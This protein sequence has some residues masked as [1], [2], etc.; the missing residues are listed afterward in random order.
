MSHPTLRR[1]RSGVRWLR[2][3]LVAAI[4]LG[5]TACL[6]HLEAVRTVVRYD[7]YTQIFDVE[8]RLIGVEARFFGCRDAEECVAAVERVLSATP[9][10]T[11]SMSLADRLLQR[12]RESGA[13]DVEV[14]LERDDERLD[15]VVRYKAPV[16]T[17]AADDTL[18]RAEWSSNGWPF[19]HYYLVIAAQESM[20]PPKR[21]KTRKVPRSG[22]A[23]TDW[24][25]EWVL[26]RWR[27]SVDTELVVSDPDD[28]EPLF[29]VIP[30][31]AGA[32]EA[33]GW[34]DAPVPIVDAADEEV[35]PLGWADE[36]DEPDAAAAAPE[37]PKGP[38]EAGSDPESPAR[39]WVYE[40]RVSGGGVTPALAAAAIEPLIPSVSRCYQRRQAELPALEGSVFLSALVKGDG[41]VL[42]TS[43]SGGV[44]DSGLLGC[45]DAVLAR[46]EFGPWGS[47]DEVSDVAIPVV[48]RVESR[49]TRTRRQ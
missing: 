45:L 31:L 13:T 1:A 22:P 40:A 11:L 10:A 3:S 16:G 27:R 32:L 47:A 41:S 19:G 49:P 7:P 20:A 37:A 36:P 48:F 28:V 6:E 4:L 14:A 17:P 18:V 12:L 15:A 25:E 43:I 5:C 30:E 35:L 2:L 34:L 24:V 26:P 38:V 42:A 8:R 46:W 29:A 39:T 33:R 23:G 21:H 44:S 9:S